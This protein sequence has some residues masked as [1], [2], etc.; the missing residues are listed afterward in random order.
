MENLN[1][2][3][4]EEKDIEAVVDIQIAGWKTAY[5]G[6]IDQDFLDSMNREEKIEKRKSTYKNSPFVVAD[7]NNEIVGFCRYCYEVISKDGE[8]YDC[9]IM[10]LYV[11]PDLKGKGI[12]KALI[13]YVKTDMKQHGKTKMILWCLKENYPSRKFYEKVGGQPIE[14]EHYAEFGGKLYSEIGFGYNLY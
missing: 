7:I 12:G 11:K 4:F 13:N 8:G 10:A 3:N 9:E 5:Q 2:R 14:C 1:I 6:I